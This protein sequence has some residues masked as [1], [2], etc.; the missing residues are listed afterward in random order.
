[1][2]AP[3][4]LNARAMRRLAAAR[5]C[6]MGRPWVLV[7]GNNVLSGTGWRYSA[8]ELTRTIDCW[9]LD[10]NLADR[11]L[12]VWD[13]GGTPSAHM[14]PHSAAL[15]SGDDQLADDMIVQAVGRVRG[16]V[17][18]FTSDVGLRGRCYAQRCLQATGDASG[19]TTTTAPTQPHELVSQHSV[20]LAWM[21]EARDPT[22]RAVERF[23]RRAQARA[24]AV[25][26]RHARDEATNVAECDNADR[27]R[28]R[29]L[30]SWFDAPSPLG[31]SVAR[32]SRHGN[33]L[34]V[35]G[36]DDATDRA[37]ADGR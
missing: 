34:Y 27:D 2:C 10:T 3:S 18:V 26:L 4:H 15:F 8:E 35:Y 5:T 21:L 14:L 9:A 6:L 37:V 19:Q 33:E 13:G 24:L 7:D 30:V 12:T 20:Y 28:L 32:T 23:D 31:L 25:A 36:G 29:T 16:P 22:P 1:M 17:V 11:V